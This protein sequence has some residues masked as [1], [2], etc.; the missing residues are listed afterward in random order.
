[1]I[2]RRIITIE[3]FFRLKEMLEGLPEDQSLA[4]EVYNSQFQDKDMI[5]H[6]MA[7]ALLFNNR[8]KFVDAVVFRFKVGSAVSLYNF[9]DIEEMNLVYKEILN[10]IIRDD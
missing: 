8:K 6:L 9:I 4:I 1:M 2:K 5:D 10:K 3:E 7:K